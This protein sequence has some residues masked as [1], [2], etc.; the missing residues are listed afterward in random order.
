MEDQS[1]AIVE[2]KPLEYPEI[3]QDTIEV[4]FPEITDFVRNMKLKSG[5]SVSYT[6]LI[7]DR[8]GN[9]GSRG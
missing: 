2:G 7:V 9:Y 3:V 6:H 4:E 1:K 5:I 8:R